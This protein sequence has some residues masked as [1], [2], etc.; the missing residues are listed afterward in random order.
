MKRKSR[1]MG[2]N[3]FQ[4]IFTSK[5]YTML[6]LLIII[7]SLTMCKSQEYID[8]YYQERDQA[9]EE[10]LEM[11]KDYYENTPKDLVRQKDEVLLVFNAEAF[12]N[13]LVILNQKDTLS[14][15]KPKSNND[16]LGM[17]LF[18]VKKNSNKVFISCSTKENIEFKLKGDYDYIEINGSYNNKWGITYSKFFPLIT[19]M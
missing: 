13:S 9:K 14:L 6:S 17:V 1:K 10:D 12:K 2:A 18:K 16:C 11:E 15:S 3:F 5:K 19:C 7:A 4:L 8:F